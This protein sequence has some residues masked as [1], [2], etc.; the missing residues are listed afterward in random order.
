M[1][2]P[3][4]PVIA[5][6]G[7]GEAGAQIAADLVSAGAIVHAF[8]P[9]VPAPAAT[10]G[11]GSDADAAR[12]A[13][14]I[15]SLTSA[16][17]AVETLKQALPGLGAGTIYADLNTGSAGFKATLPR[18][19][20]RSGAAFVDIA[21]IAPVPGRGLR[22]PM[23]ASGPAADDCARLLGSLGANV[24]VLPGPPGTAASRKLVRSVF[25]KGL[26]AAVTEALRAGRAAGCED[27]LRDDI[28]Q[29]LTG[30]SAAT[31]DRLEEG[32][33]RHARRRMDEMKPAGDLLD[34]LGVPSRVA[35]ASQGWLAQLMT[36]ADR[37]LQDQP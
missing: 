15:M 34:E 24:T 3:S 16:H 22:T 32:S 12:G 10:H 7:P 9:K 19:A 36:E 4:A 17:E 5:V 27:W 2:T 21:L 30:A 29:V 6:L 28:R 33:V 8:D 23:L 35:R 11:F 37:Q 26:A 1:G 20:A 25:Y 13:R 31:V 14:I 18:T